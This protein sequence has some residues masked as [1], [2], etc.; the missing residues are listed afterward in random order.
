MTKSQHW[1]AA[2]STH[3]VKKFRLTESYGTDERCLELE[4]RETNNSKF[5]RG[6]LWINTKPSSIQKTNECFFFMFAYSFVWLRKNFVLLA[7][8]RNSTQ[9]LRRRRFLLL[10]IL[11]LYT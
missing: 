2:S 9:L 1:K 10:K 7:F 8:V 5:D 11:T 6:D 3:S 4:L